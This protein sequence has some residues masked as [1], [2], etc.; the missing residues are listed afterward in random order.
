MNCI[1]IDDEEMARAILTQF[2][3]SHTNIEVVATFSNAMDAIKFL[4]QKP[5]FLHL[6]IMMLN[7]VF[8]KL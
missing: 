5:L 8:K 4:N 3:V 1:I 7:C 2:I 6:W